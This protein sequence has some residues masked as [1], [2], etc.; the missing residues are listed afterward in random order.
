MEHS[1]YWR[2]GYHVKF[3]IGSCSR[4][5]YLP[6]PFS[7]FSGDITCDSRTGDMQLLLELR[8]CLTSKRGG[9]DLVVSR[10]WSF[11]LTISSTGTLVSGVVVWLL[12]AYISFSKIKMSRRYI[13]RVEK[14]LWEH[15]WNAVPNGQSGD[16]HEINLL[17]WRWPSYLDRHFWTGSCQS[18]LRVPCSLSRQCL[19]LCC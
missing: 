14:T 8:W 13:P 5:R 19:C 16:Y 3:P 2:S 10:R 11:W 17:R 12:L 9:H 15:L 6:G 4:S 18:G 1:R 7:S